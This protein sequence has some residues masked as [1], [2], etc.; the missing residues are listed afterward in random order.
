MVCLSIAK[1][2]IKATHLES[3]E[4]VMKRSFSVIIFCLILIF[5]LSAC[6][7]A[8]VEQPGCAHDRYANEEK[9]EDAVYE[10]F[11][12]SCNETVTETV[13]GTGH[14]FAEEFTVDKKP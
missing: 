6:S 5:S 14:D 13:T 12:E 2:E 8:Q 3:K 7:E 11:C 4:V 9:C 1:F 10:Y